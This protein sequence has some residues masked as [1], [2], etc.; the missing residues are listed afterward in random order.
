MASSPRN[1]LFITA[2]QWRGDT[3]GCA[4]HPLVQTPHLDQLAQE[5]VSFRNHWTQTAPC[6][7]ARASLYTSLYQM[8]HRVA[9]NGT[10][11]DRRLTNLALEARRQGYDPTLFGYT[12]MS[13]DPRDHDRNDPKLKTY[14]GV[15]PGMTVGVSLTESEKPWL[16]WLKTLGYEGLDADSVYR[17]LQSAAPGEAVM[18][19]PAR[20]AKEHSNTAFLCGELLKWLSVREDEP[21]FAHLSL[22]RP[23]PPW[24]AP[25]PYH[26]LY[27]PET[28]PT[29]ARGASA[30]EESEQHLLLKTLHEIVPMS[31]FHRDG[32]GPVAE[33]D[34]AQVRQA[35]AA[36]YG[37]IT[38]VDAHLGRIFA[39]LKASGQ[40]ENTL[41]V[42]TT[43]HGEML[44]DH[45][46]FGKHGYFDGAYHIPLIIHDPERPEQFGTVVEAFTE[47]ID[48]TPTILEWIGATPPQ[49]MDGLS[50]MPF[51][52]GQT[53][54]RW[55]DAVHFEFDF[56]E[57]SSLQPMIQERFGLLPDQCSLC[58]IRD[59]H[60]KYVHFTAL[61]PLLFDLKADPQ[62]LTNLAEHPEHQATVLK[63]AQKMLSWT[64][65]HRDR[66]LVNISY[67]SGTPLFWEGPRF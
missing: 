60:F 32:Q 17:P 50:L 21:W 65:N 37:L 14:E 58:V 55:R 27:D 49:Q 29:P 5:G 12:D 25:E 48:T 53:P 20:Y 56:R 54:E 2:D 66:T 59:E 24:I 43:D 6:S 30:Q 57:I 40:W 51:L 42:F 1:V 15:L 52:K 44:G 35:R 31:A 61:P 16:A 4:G 67:E 28:V 10:P 38:E 64:F 34:E 45:Y 63:Y 8:N 3:L 22:L 62:E 33:A 9:N 26:T 18:G 19:P 13:A 39:Y 47:T 41:V 36:Y 23:H 46:L 7:P 11:L